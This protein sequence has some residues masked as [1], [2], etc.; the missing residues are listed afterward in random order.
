MAKTVLY[1]GSSEFG[2]YKIVD[3][4]YDGRP[5]RLL[6]AGSDTPQSGLATDDNP[7]LLFDYNQ[8]FLELALSIR[9][10]RVLVIGGG[11][12]TLPKALLERLESV[13]RI[14]VVELDP[15][16]P[17]LAR[18]YFGVPDDPRLHVMV[19]DG[20]LYINKAEQ[21]YDL[22]VVDAFAEFII[23]RPLMT[24]QAA[25]QYARLLGP[26]GV[27]TINFISRYYTNKLQLT[28]QL[29]AT[30]ER[31]FTHVEFDPA[32]PYY[33]KR[34]EQNMLMIAHDGSWEHFDYLQS[35]PVTVLPTP[36][37]TDLTDERTP[38]P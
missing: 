34:A 32:D 14:D 1:E 22:I 37:P 10:K 7:E 31:V 4:I 19:G 33:D 8:R 38:R 23:P 36:Q 21:T 30:F 24:V 35:A 9:P 18:Q 29:K 27:F 3:L 20:R 11:A 6:Y 2:H 17:D 12:L 28:H 13:T 25:R 16:L 26:G 15:L 5:S